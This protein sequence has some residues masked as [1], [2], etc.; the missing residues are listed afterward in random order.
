MATV[1]VMKGGGY[2]GT[3]IEALDG[4][5]HQGLRAYVSG[6]GSSRPFSRME[7]PSTATTAFLALK[8]AHS[9]ISNTE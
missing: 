1:T 9:R 5:G 8:R 2:A 7:I 3:T 6:Q 4:I